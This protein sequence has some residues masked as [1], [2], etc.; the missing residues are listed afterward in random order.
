MLTLRYEDASS[1]ARLLIEMQITF[2]I[3]DATIT[4]KRLFHFVRFE[5]NI[6]LPRGFW[7]KL[8][9]TDFI[10]ENLIDNLSSCRS[11]STEKR[12]KIAPKKSENAHHI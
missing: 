1:K 3:L 4:C 12:Y 5:V 6:Y 8:Y 2:Y 11:K 10:S 7:N 9:E